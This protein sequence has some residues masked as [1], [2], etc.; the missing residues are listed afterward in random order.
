M[1]LRATEEYR[2]TPAKR[3]IRIGD[4]Y[5]VW[6]EPDSNWAYREEVYS[7]IELRSLKWH[8]WWRDIK[9]S[10]SARGDGRNLGSTQGGTSMTH[11]LGT[12]QFQLDDGAVE[13]KRG[14]AGSAGWDL[15]VATNETL[16]SGQSG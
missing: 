12:V 3:M 4:G 5:R 15:S 10:L 13:P 14:T 2:A 1:T 16:A 11:D 8:R 6:A 9:R 7:T